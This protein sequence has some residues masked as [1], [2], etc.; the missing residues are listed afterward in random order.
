MKN[1]EDKPEYWHDPQLEE[2]GKSLIQKHHNHLLEAEISYLVTSRQKI[3][4]GVVEIGHS[5]RPSGLL[6]HYARADFIVI[7]ADDFW[8]GAE[9]IKREALVDHEL[10]HCSVEYD[11]SGERSWIIRRHDIEEFTA[12]VDRHG[13]WTDEL[14]QFGQAVARQLELPLS[15]DE[16]PK[17]KATVS[18]AAG[19]L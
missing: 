17:K 7:I 18:P 19:P 9:R 13:L 4:A 5:K 6:K 8:H 16:K 1:G 14:K 3:K 2:I 11:E 15:G 10:C 12:V